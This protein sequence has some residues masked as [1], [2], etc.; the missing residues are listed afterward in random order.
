MNANLESSPIQTL[1]VVDD[2]EANR[3]LAQNTLEDEGYR[4]ILAAGGAEGIAAFERE[5]PDCVLL[6]VR[7]PDIDGF[8][9][10][11][12]IRRLPGGP[13]TPVIFLTA[14]RDI[15]TFD[16]AL[17]AGGDDFL[18]KPVRPTELVV[19]VQTVL[20]LR[21]LRTELHEHYAL[22]KRQRDDVMRLQLQKERL[23]AFVVHDLK[24]PVNSM[25]LHAQVL[26]RDRTL[27]EAARESA[28]Q[29]RTEARQL[30]RMILNLLDLS[31]ADEGKLTP[32]RAVV[33]LD[34]LVAEVLLELEES[35]RAR[36]VKLSSELLVIRI[37]VDADLLRRLLANLVE[38]AIRHAP[39]ASVVVV[40]SRRAEGATELR[41]IDR[42]EGVPPE[43]QELVFDP[44]VQLEGSEI[45]S[46][47]GGRGLGLSFCKLAVEAHG[48]RMWIEDAAPG[49]AFCARLPDEV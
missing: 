37:Q 21:R 4:V 35:A 38:N 15:D 9:V 32:K 36:R 8:T 45:P 2:N 19:R 46:S 26:L 30:N 11:E 43:M 34:A 31:K 10:C 22:L 20:K 12:R 24:N 39:A 47:R 40:R 13:D 28:A 6:D 5:Q 7:M 1:L 49:A 48:G 42:G 23:T 14:L 44:F 33:A 25:D 3:L 16:R 41:V 27:S 29:I 17:R 18:T